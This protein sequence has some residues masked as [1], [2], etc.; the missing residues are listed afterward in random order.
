MS[1]IALETPEAQ[2]LSSAVHSKIVD[3][4]W[5]QDDDTSLAEYIVLMLANGKTQDQIA[6]E[7]AGELLQDADGTTEF[8]QWLFQQVDNMSG[9]AGP[10]QNAPQP[11][12]ESGLELAQESTD[13]ANAE[14]SIPAAYEMDMAD[15][16]PE[17]APRGPKGLHG[18]RAQS[19]RGRGNHKSSDSALHR[20]RGNDRIN[21]HGNTRGAPKGP[22][23][24]QGVRPGM[25]KALNNIGLAGQPPGIPPQMMPNPGQPGQNMPPM[26]PQ[27][28]MEFMAAMWE[29]QTRMLA[30]ITG[31]MPENGGFPQGGQPQ[32]N[33]RSLFDRVEPG[34]G[35]GGRGRG[36]RAGGGQNGHAKSN[37]QSDADTNMEG[38][39]QSSETTA[40]DVES[41]TSGQKKSQDPFDTMCHFNWRCTNKDCAY[42]HQ[43]PVASTSV[44]VDMKTTCSFATA[45]KNAKCTGRHPSPALTKAQQ[46]DTIC[47]FFPRCTN[48]GCAF[49]HPSA[50]L[51][52]F[53]DNC[54]TPNCTFTHLQERCRYNPCNNLRCP[55]KHEP[56]QQQAKTL[57]D[58]SWTPDKQAE[59]DAAK[60]NNDHVSD[61]KF[62]DEE[63]EE[64]L[65]KPEGAGETAN[66]AAAAEPVT[67]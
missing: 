21:T 20:V 16:A 36:G 35:R 2:A 15:S 4:G 10:S 32:Q 9:G 53:G 48:P 7:L 1:A 55:F 64:E 31:I 61:R 17:N 51:C 39:D 38:A 56:G 29:Q 23:N 62:V 60:D 24:S 5:T 33:G 42:A 27:Q 65:I 28:Q 49:K 8:A 30:Q 67:A 66:G 43:S 57:G 50:P 3:Q 6:S 19:N 46:A 37:K 41:T 25:Q 58:Y 12:Q 54:K 59:K 40:M 47:K 52:R 11:Q 63:A 26:N 45:C 13:S 22:R 14:S 44:A 34:R 18:G